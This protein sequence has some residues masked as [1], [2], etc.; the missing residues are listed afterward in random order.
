MSI[1]HDPIQP[2]AGLEEL[3]KT[4]QDGGRKG[5]NAIAH[6]RHMDGHGSNEAKQ[7]TMNEGAVV[8]SILEG[9]VNGRCERM[10]P[11]KQGPTAGV[12]P[13]GRS[14]L[15]NGVDRINLYHGINCSK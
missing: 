15:T 14:S 10:S 12:H 11:Y 5:A 2:H 13:Q 3:W 1:S 7:R 9:K 6:N 8:A 4:R